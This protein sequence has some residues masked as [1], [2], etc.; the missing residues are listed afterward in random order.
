MPIEQ[1]RLPFLEH[2]VELRRRLVIILATIAV[3]STVLYVKPAYEAIMKW[4]FWPI[5][6]LIQPGDLKVFGP[7]ESFTYRFKVS[8]FAAIVV[9]SPIIIWQIMAFFLPALKPGERKWAIPTFGAAVVL[10][11]SG[12]GFAYGVILHP[13][14]QFMF[15]QTGGM[16]EILPAADRFLS[17]IMLLLIGFGLAFEIPIIVFYAIG[18]GFIRYKKLRESWRFVY[19]GL[20]VIASVA[21]PDWSPITMGALFGSLALLYEGSLLLAKVAF[22]RRIK[23]QE[24]ELAELGA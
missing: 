6:D 21:T 3:G 18:F 4:L 11:L 20:I 5:R 10:F 24:A 22:A 9:F 8:L 14:F 1:K 23:E 19:V 15:A 7:F 2:V 17:G 12:A 16:V 13:A